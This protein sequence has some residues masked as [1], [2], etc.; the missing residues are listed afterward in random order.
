MQDIFT[1]LRIRGVGLALD[2]FGTSTAAL[3]DLYRVPYSEIKIDHSLLADVELEH[4]ARLIVKAL[5]DLAHTLELTVCAQGVETRETLEF[6]R[7]AGFDTAQGRVFGGSMNATEIER[8]VDAWPA[9]APA[10]TGIWRTSQLAQMPDAGATR[11]LRRHKVA[12]IDA[13]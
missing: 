12:P 4:D 13:P 5:A 6:V 9:S 10:A 3:T 1:R 2:N 7:A 8:M 11:R